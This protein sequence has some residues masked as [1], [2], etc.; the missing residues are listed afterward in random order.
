[1]LSEVV[2]HA[3]AKEKLLKAFSSERL[4]HGYIFYGPEG[5]GK[6]FL[7]RE[8]IKYINCTSRGVDSCGV[9][10]TCKG[11]SE[12]NHPDLAVIEPVRAVIKIEQV[13]A[14]KALMGLKAAQCEYRAVLIN[15]ADRMNGEAS[16][17]LLKLLE[18][19]V[20]GT[21]IILV[22][23]NI[24]AIRETIRS[25]AQRIDFNGLSREDTVRV[26]KANGIEG[27]RLEF[28]AR[29]A[30]GC[31]GRAVNFTQ[32]DLFPLREEAFRFAAA[33][34]KTGV[35]FTT[36]ELA[37]KYGK[38]KEEE[39]E[40]ETGDAEAPA[41]EEKTTNSQ[42]TLYV[43]NHLNDMLVSIF[44]DVL[45]VNS[46]RAAEIVNVDKNAVIK[47][48]SGVYSAQAAAG[49]LG[50]LNKIKGLLKN[51]INYDLSAGNIILRGGK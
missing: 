28:L 50:G 6:V 35:F 45:L 20:A 38:F 30:E 40:E 22:A 41:P 5:C 2:G 1:M 25:R 15:G 9:C 24:H 27:N 13:R 16:D 23:S 14:A 18:E 31:P 8:I 12:K 49:I 10:P 43:R 33:I 47:E 48:L 34:G 26:L 7:A 17:A 21:L 36:K 51:S 11:L 37:K 42:K 46:G 19:P 44:R 3:K 32:E 4:A 39:I 29:S